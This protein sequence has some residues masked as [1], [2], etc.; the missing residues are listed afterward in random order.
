LSALHTGRLY[1]LE[2]IPDTHFCYRL[3][4]PQGHSMAGGFMSINIPVTPSGIESA[5]FHTVNSTSRTSNCQCSLFPRIIQLSGFSANGSSPELI[6]IRAV[7]LYFSNCYTYVRYVC[8]GYLSDF[9]AAL[10]GFSL[11]TPK[12]RRCISCHCSYGNL[13][14]FNKYVCRFSL[15]GGKL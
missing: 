5:T 2:I 12:P 7:L 15:L 6:R 14:V 3:S 1:P 13:L 8:K 11:N 9:M 4:Q 10:S